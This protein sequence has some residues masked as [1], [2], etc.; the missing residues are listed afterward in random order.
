MYTGLAIVNEVLY[1]ILEE[2]SF[3]SEDFGIS[4]LHGSILSD[5]NFLQFVFDLIEKVGEAIEVT[6][7]KDKFSQLLLSMSELFM[8]ILYQI[9]LSDTHDKYIQWLTNFVSLIRKGLG[10]K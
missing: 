2:P 9:G 5:L 3:L 4:Q 8:V 6:T 1:P 10:N 7:Q